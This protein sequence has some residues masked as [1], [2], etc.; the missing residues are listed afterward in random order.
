MVAVS[1]IVRSFVIMQ[2]GIAE[3]KRLVSVSFEVLEPAN[4]APDPM[5]RCP[6]CD[7]RYDDPDE[8]ELC[9]LELDDACLGCG[10]LVCE[11]LQGESEGD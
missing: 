10:M 4:P 11:C 2:P 5:P 1:P 9:C 3:L 8:A 6:N 7:T